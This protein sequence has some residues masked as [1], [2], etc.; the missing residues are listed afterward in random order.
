MSD[1]WPLLTL[2]IVLGLAGF[3]LTLRDW[4]VGT[5]LLAA[6]LPF[7][8]LMP[9]VGAGSM[10]LLSAVAL[11]GLLVHLLHDRALLTRALVNLRTG[12]SL[13]MLA[14]VAVAALSTLWA[15]SAP[16]ALGRTVTFAGLFLLLHLFALLD[17]PWLR[18]AWT[19]L[20]ASAALTV[21]VA[22]I[23][24]GGA[25]FSEEGRFAAGGLNPNDYAGLLVVILFAG[26]GL[27]AGNAWTRAALA[28]VVLVAILLSGSR[29]AFVALAVAPL[30]YLLISPPAARKPAL[31]RVGAVYLAALAV[32][33]GAYALD[34]GQAAAVHARAMT[35][36]D[37]RNED[38]WAG[39][40]D[41]WRGGIAMFRAAPVLGVG[42]GNFPIVGPSV[43]AMPRRASAAGPG[44]VAHN[45][46]VGLAAELGVI[47]L[48]AFAWLLV[49]AFARARAT[50][51]M[52]MPTYGG[53]LL[54]GL[55]A[56]V[57][58]GLSLSWEY[59]KILYV[60]IG[61]ALALAPA[62]TTVPA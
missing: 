4:R 61:S 20:L 13:G 59:S 11:L 10:K 44:P 24:G 41:T 53:A 32:V 51:G 8:G 31:V 22:L 30:V 23:F 39:R 15:T 34:G 2:L 21:P 1:Y 45:V 25:A 52:G 6:A 14:L 19:A 58:I 12:V 29:T 17:A 37:Y 57:L 60:V 7:E 42:A 28:I 48:A 38:T 47:G 26:V 3:A 49:A 54:L 9:Q 40:I 56:C 18:R 16:A 50:V 62:S 33:G 36:R 5:L 35:I 55:I 27:A 43:S 46:F